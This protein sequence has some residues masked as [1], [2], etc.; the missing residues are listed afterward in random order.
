MA[1]TELVGSG[2]ITVIL[3]GGSGDYI[4]P[5]GF[6]VENIYW[7]T[8]AET[9]K[10]ILREYCDDGRA[11]DAMPFIPLLGTTIATLGLLPPKVSIRYMIDYAASTTPAD[12]ILTFVGRWG[13]VG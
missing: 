12:N 1:H 8:T 5:K 6:M 10:M 3:N 9:D 7:L 11:K 2:F 4:T 13:V